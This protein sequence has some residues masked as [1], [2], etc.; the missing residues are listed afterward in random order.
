MQSKFVKGAGKFACNSH[1]GGLV[2]KSIV[3][4]T[5][6]KK[7]NPR[8]SAYR[9]HFLKHQFE[10]IPAKR[11][12][13]DLL[14]N[15]Y[16]KEDNFKYLFECAVNYAAL[17]GKTIEIPK[18]N[19]YERTNRLFHCFA[20]ILPKNHW[21]NF[22]ISDNKIFWT[23]YYIHDWHDNIFYW[24]PVSFI[25]YLNGQIKEI[26]MS[27]MHLFIRKNQLMHFCY[28]Y[29]YE[30]IFYTITNDYDDNP[31]ILDLFH[32]YTK[33][34]ISNFFDE[35]NNH[36]P[37]EIISELQEYEPANAQEARLLDCFKK[38]L[39]FIFGDDC[40]MNYD[41]DPNTEHYPEEYEDIEPVTL[42]RIIR[43]VYDI[44]DFVTNEL[45]SMT[46]QHMQDT[47]SVTPT[48]YLTLH[49][50]TKLFNPGDY[51]ERFS[52]WFLEMVEIANEIN[53]I[54]GYE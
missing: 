13:S 33:G 26:A 50:D 19:I 22:D 9:S 3:G 1:L 36:E 6:R 7:A 17:L 44:N 48:S 35:L 32:S 51:P 47:Y 5:P 30:Y 20:G 43:F 4:D 39:P 10:I 46:N 25:N 24:M 52:K 28:C 34:K 2:G 27:F 15:E 21:L 54:N 31:E 8:S 45:E 49:P 14:F 42:D 12:I 38:G 37:C 40:I 18:G 23:V 16:M 29:E 11:D 41:Y 53:E